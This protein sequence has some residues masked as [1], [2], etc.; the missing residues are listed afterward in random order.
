MNSDTGLRYVS[1]V[2]SNHAELRGT[3]MPPGSSL[4]SCVVSSP[5]HVQKRCRPRTRPA[6]CARMFPVDF[7]S[8][9]MVSGGSRWP[10][11]QSVP[12]PSHM[13]LKS[14]RSDT[15]NVDMTA[16]NNNIPMPKRSFACRRGTLSTRRADLLSE[17]GR[18]GEIYRARCVLWDNSRRRTSCMCTRSPPW[19]D[20]P[21]SSKLSASFLAVAAG[22]TPSLC[23]C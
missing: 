17:H 20:S 19:K 1:N 22:S 3:T 4:P 14:D 2:H 13:G 21:T 7:S 11:I 6:R 16:N 15:P 9:S 8:F 5:T 12:S 23:A 18:P 10:D